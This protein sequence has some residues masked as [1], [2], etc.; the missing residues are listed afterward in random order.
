MSLNCTFSTRSGWSLWREWNWWILFLSV[1]DDL[2]GE[3]VL[4]GWLMYSGVI[5]Q[6]WS[7]RIFP[8]PLRLVS[9]MGKK[10]TLASYALKK[11]KMKKKER[12]TN[13]QPTA[14]VIQ[15]KSLKDK[16]VGDKCSWRESWAVTCLLNGSSMFGYRITCC[17][18][19]LCV[20]SEELL[21]ICKYK[22]IAQFL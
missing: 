7:R 15:L 20:S 14:N 21:N 12:K 1:P 18:S 22:R 6:I 4:L 16:G 8:K 3:Q 10:P 17:F 19:L 13:Y 11:K 2:S 9:L 5:V